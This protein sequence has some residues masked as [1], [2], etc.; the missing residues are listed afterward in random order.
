[1]NNNQELSDTGRFSMKRSN[2]KG[3]FY[4]R[5]PLYQFSKEEQSVTTSRSFKDYRIDPLN[6][7][8]L[9]EGWI[10]VLP[11]SL[12]LKNRE[13]NN[14]V[15][16]SSTNKKYRRVKR[17]YTFELTLLELP[18]NLFKSLRRNYRDG[19]FLNYTVNNR[20]FRYMVISTDFDND[21]FELRRLINIKSNKYDKKRIRKI[22]DKLKNEKLSGWIL[23]KAEDI[24]AK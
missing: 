8:E 3:S 23:K 7:D 19:N 11:K 4:H 15:K 9:K 13:F 1:M 18:N 12:L 5:L 2:K 22:V 21:I 24:L 14:N 20:I 16:V 10:R 6:E 17:Y